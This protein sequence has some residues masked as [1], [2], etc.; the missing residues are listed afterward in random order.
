MV[1][2]PKVAE[3]YEK[4]AYER[5][6]RILN[7]SL[8]FM[9][10]LSVGITGFYLLFPHF[11]ILILFGKTYLPISPLLWLF[12][13]AYSMFSFIYALCMYNL[14]IKRYSF[15]W[16]LVVVNIIELILITLFHE[17]LHQVLTMFSLSLSLLVAG[18]FTYTYSRRVE[19]G[20]K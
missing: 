6:R 5:V 14:S 19:T 7:L 18:L 11:I 12:A 15:I 8:F 16:M 20:S 10:L 9:F 4:R 13:V 2:F 17:T 1:M 3:S